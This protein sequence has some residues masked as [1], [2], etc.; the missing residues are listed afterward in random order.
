MIN[1]VLVSA[2]ENLQ[3]HVKAVSG[4]HN[5]P[6]TIALELQK[7]AAE[8][9]RDEVAHILGAN[10]QVVLLD[11]G[12]STTGVRVL[13]ALSQEAPD[14]AIMAAGPALHA[15]ALLQVIRAGASEYLPR[16][17][18][19]E[20]VSA[21][22]DRVRRRV[23]KAHPDTE[24]DRGDVTTLFSPKGGTG[25]TTLAVNLALILQERTE[26]DVAL[27][28]LS[29]SLGTSALAMGLNP[30]YSYLDVIQNFHRIDDEL[31]PSFLEVHESGVSV[32]ASPPKAGDQN[33]PSMDEV[34]ALL[35]FFRRH[36]G[37][38]VVDA[39]HSLTNAVDT[40]FMDSAHRLIVTT[41]EL[42]TLRN[43]KR[44]LEIFPDH[45]EEREA[46]RLV[47]NQFAEGLGITLQD[48]EDGLGLP[49]DFVIP[50]AQKL[51]TESLNLGRPA[52]LTGR[53]AFR[54]SVEKIGA[55][56]SGTKA[57]AAQ[58]SGLLRALVEPFRSAAAL[59]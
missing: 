23:H 19:P 1:C 10:P 53:S 38:V 6:L 30:R 17:F 57:V 54:R 25:V 37:H 2:E 35:R 56:I 26:S 14:V 59:A 46:P 32:L 31:F 36:F 51:T 15:D 5:S 58:T 7:S 48:L 44:A 11:L 27:L 40:A 4:A 49:V 8:V 22:L 42:P 3:R 29:P 20:E 39:G 55:E 9:S 18:T 41:P 50:Q 24:V 12:G 45:G 13:E 28:D 16:P 52:V 21:A 33:G 43:V 47:L 34:M